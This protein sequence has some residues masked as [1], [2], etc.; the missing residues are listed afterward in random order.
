MSDEARS[1]EPSAPGVPPR[2]AERRIIWI[3]KSIFETAEIGPNDDFFELGGDSLMA[4][5][6]MSALDMEFGVVLPVS[7]LLETPTPRGLARVVLKSTA[8]SSSGRL[9]RVKED[10]EGAP[11]FCVHGMTGHPGATRRIATVIN[12]PRAVYGLRASGLHDGELP[13]PT[14]EAIAAQYIA[15]I[16]S[17]KPHGPYV[18]IGQCGTSMVAYEMAQ[19]L[20][21]AGDDLIGLILVDPPV[22]GHTE[23]ISRSGPALKQV[24]NAG[25]KLTQQAM[26]LARTK[27]NLTANE[28][29]AMVRMSLWGALRTYVPKP[30]AGK[31]LLIHTKKTGPG[32]LNPTRGFPAYVRDLKAVQMPGGHHAMLMDL[33]AETSEHIARFLAAAESGGSDRSAAVGQ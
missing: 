12:P 11:I 22:S 18:L 27:S 29:S 28:R 1:L 7:S 26:H 21:G 10:G 31:M 30:F 32:L 24:Q 4:T 17:V 16:K 33:I 15:D 25:V 6:L 9:I 14:V 2:A 20:L 23:W 8:G 5:N 19:Q 3:F 13:L